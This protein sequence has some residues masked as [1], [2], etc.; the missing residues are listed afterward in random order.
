VHNHIASLV[1]FDEAMYS[2]SVVEVATT[3][4]FLEDQETVPLPMSKE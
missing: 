1:A 2:A 3:H 4:C